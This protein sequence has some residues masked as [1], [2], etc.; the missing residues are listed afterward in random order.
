MK[1]EQALQAMREGKK[2]RRKSI[3]NAEYFIKNKKM[4]CKYFAYGEYKY[5][6]YIFFS[7]ILA[8]DWE[9]VDDNK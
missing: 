7:E 6:S 5:D 9:V 4:M 2:V 3:E 1:F 8:E